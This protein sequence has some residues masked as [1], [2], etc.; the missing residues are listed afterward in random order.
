MKTR[1]QEILCITAR[2]TAK[3]K[4]FG[5]VQSVDELVLDRFEIYGYG[6]GDEG[7]GVVVVVV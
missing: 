4:D 6:G 2:A 7:L 3:I 1:L 5:T